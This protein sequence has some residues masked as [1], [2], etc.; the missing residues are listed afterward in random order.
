MAVVSAALVLRVKL[1]HRVDSHNGN[2]GL[3]STLEL[4][5]LAHRRLQ[6]AHL[7]AVDDAAFAEIQS[8]VLVVLLL[9]Q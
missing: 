9:G 6:Y 1:N 2:T 7:Q 5:D 3:N 4:L 8:V